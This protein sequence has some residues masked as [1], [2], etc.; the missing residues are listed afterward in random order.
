MTKMLIVSSDTP[1]ED[2]QAAFTIVREAAKDDKLDKITW[3]SNFARS[4]TRFDE[5]IAAI[6]KDFKVF[7][8]AYSKFGIEARA[9]FDKVGK[10]EKNLN[11]L[12]KPQ[13]EKKA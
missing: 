12:N 1:E 7:A 8:E 5:R 6:E 11:E 4:I 3:Y 10:M 2:I 13:K 9:I